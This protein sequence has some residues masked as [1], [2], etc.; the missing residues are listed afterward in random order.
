M[1]KDV[2]VSNV[3]DWML[4]R[5]LTLAAVVKGRHAQFVTEGDAMAKSMGRKKSDGGGKKKY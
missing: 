1:I 2:N 3:R 4:K 5:R